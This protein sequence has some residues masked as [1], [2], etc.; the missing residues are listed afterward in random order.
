M[1]APLFEDIILDVMEHYPQYRWADAL[2]ESSLVLTRLYLRIPDIQIKRAWPLIQL[3][4][5]IGNALGGK[6]RGG[7]EAPDPSSVWSAS[8]LAPHFLPRGLSDAP[9]PALEPQ[10]CY[11]FA[12]ALEGG[13]LEGASW[14]LQMLAA[15][16]D[17]ARV[18]QV[19]H[20]YAELVTDS[21]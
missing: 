10:H 7:E 19:G 15:N 1:D 9:E 17:L 16:D 20:R 13:L 11:A 21:Q 5:F 6:S 4:A 18:T 3:Q 8:E 12:F 2:E 14:V